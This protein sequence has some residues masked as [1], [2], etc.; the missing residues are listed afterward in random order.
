MKRLHFWI[1]LTACLPLS[2]VFSQ[3]LNDHTQLLGRFQ[4]NLETHYSDIWGY[5]ADGREYALLGTYEGVS[6]VD[7]TDPANPVEVDFIP[8]PQS[9][10]RDIKTYQ[11]YA[12]VVH[13]GND[14]QH[15]EPGMQIIDLSALP[16][17]AR[18]VTTYRTNMGDGT[19]HN[20][21][22]DG[23]F[24]YIA[25]NSEFPGALILD[26]SLPEQ[27]QQVGAW[28]ETYWHDVVALR[29]TVYGSAMFDG[30]VEI[31]DATDKSQLKLITKVTYPD[32]FTHNA[33]MTD[34]NRYLSQTDEAAGLPVNFWDLSDP[35]NP[36]R[37][38]TFALPDPAIAHN[39]H[40]RGNYA[41]ISYYCDGLR[42]LDISQRRVP[43]DVGY[44]DTYPDDNFRHD[45]GF[46]GAWG[47]FPFLPSG[48]I[49]ISDMT[50]GLHIVA[51]D[52][53]R[54]GYI[55]GVIRDATSGEGIP[56]V[57][58]QLLNPEFN[59][60]KTT[61]LVS[62]DGT[63][64]MGARPGVR[65]FRFSKFGY[66]DR[67]IEV[68]LKPGVTLPLDVSL[69]PLPRVD[70]TVQARDDRGQPIPNARV[71]L[72]AE[73]FRK[74]VPTDDAGDVTLT[75]PEAHYRISLIQ[76]GWLRVDREVTLSAPQMQVEL[77]TRPGY[78][79]TFTE[80][81]PWQLSAAGD[82]SRFS[83]FIARPADHPL[84]FR[85]PAEDYT[86]DAEG[87]AVLSRAWHGRTT[88]TSPPFDATRFKK[89]V[90][91]FARFYN[92]YR[93]ASIQANDTLKVMLSNDD[94]Q[95]WTEI[96][97][98]TT[99]DREWTVVRIPIDPLLTPTQ[100]MRVRFINIEGPDNGT[101]RAS[102]FCMLDDIQIVPESVLTS[103]TAS[104]ALPERLQLL[105]NFPN[106]FNPSTTVV[107][108][109]PRDGEVTI[110]VYNILGQ[111]VWAQ[112]LGF[113]KAGRNQ[114]TLRLPEQPSGVYFWSVRFNG[115]ESERRKM[116]LLQ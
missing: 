56:E 67:E 52:S 60:G 95:T 61:V 1:W 69:Q 110:Q 84:G 80:A 9:L 78:L 91:Q 100:A 24:V 44:Y 34:D 53:L 7:V 22:I 37:V 89:P 90:L 115:V 85:L 81:E 17:S 72:F 79:E 62:D 103:V 12:Y 58:I 35:T 36:K 54:A 107:W 47:A 109:Q 76:W 74:T 114:L 92:P 48:N 93:W 29:D 45:C 66:F 31:V 13:D 101:P 27:P 82:D 41:F 87:L 8:G 94:G 75:V 111:R 46:Q 116:L 112:P 105:P 96:A 86:G 65:R 16:D 23:Q 88:L 3:A 83:W 98:Y 64:I 77:R 51:F 97:A 33:W 63:Y 11:H 70:L 73:G 32:A 10:W 5:A 15:P 20:L 99:I 26:L 108:D 104:R 14:D 25:G 57:D 2:V 102:A 55:E 28:T 59:E 21:Y 30:A 40:I 38:A 43:V 18:L 71:V 49:L 42:I 106:P 4:R 6:I 113:Q 39:T 68:T 50:Y 19:A